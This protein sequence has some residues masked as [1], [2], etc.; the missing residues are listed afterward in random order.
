V[1]AACVLLGA[2]VWDR[3]ATG[4]RV[5]PAAAPA[6]RALITGFADLGG[7]YAS[8]DPTEREVWFDRTV[9]AGAGVVRLPLSWEIT[10]GPQRPP[11]P[12][13]P[14]SASYDFTAIDAAVRDAEARDLAVLVTI[15]NAP[16]WAEAPGRPRSA[17]AGVWRPNPSDLARFAQAV[18][19]RYSGD[20]DPDGPGPASLLPAVQGLEIWNEPNLS[21][22]LLPQYK[23][24]TAV[25]VGLYRKMLNASYAAV[26]AVNPQARVVAS[27]AGPYGDPPGGSR[28][29]PVEFW[30]QLLCVH[31]EMVRAK[32]TKKSAPP[33]R[34][35]STPGCPAPARFDILGFHAVNT[36]GGPRRSAIDPNDASSADLDRIV[37]VLRGAE[38]A[39]TV[40][41]GRHPVW[42]TEMW[43]DKA[44]ATTVP[45]GRWIE[46]AFYLLWKEG[47]SVV[48]NLS[49]R[50]STTPLG[51]IGP[52]VG[53]G[54]SG[55]FFVDGRPKPAYTAFRFPFVTERINERTLLA[56]GKAPAGGKL[57]IQRRQRG[58]WIAVKHL[59][60][61][62]G[63]VFTAQLPLRGKQRLRA[64]VA[65]NQSLVWNQR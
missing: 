47:A 29:R 8:A 1:V 14:G 39:G 31:P 63:A 64:A 54:R 46:Q 53:P 58:R 62:Q 25:S 48:I 19:S 44:N 65:G 40:L 41:P 49:L 16:A 2:S 28:V 37:R 12:T 3:V 24:T 36:T 56:W 6:K 45:L 13:N 32:K 23:G 21:G 43:F 57:V 60:V 5:V 34:Y 22:W 15:S 35:V 4:D 26:K 55:I 20:F 61:G 51:D 52:K 50:D 10:A 30:Q 18:A 33:V 59:N 27:G 17:V 42:T 38:R 7:L 9:E 11:D